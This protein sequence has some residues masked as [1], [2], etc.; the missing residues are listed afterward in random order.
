MD[1]IRILQISDIH[2]VTTPK[3]LDGYSKMREMF[4][5]DIGDYCNTFDRKFNHLLIC[6]DIAQSG[7]ESQYEKAK[8]YIQQIC[9]KI[10]C[11]ESEVYVVP[12]NHDKVR[13]NG[14]PAV[15]NL[16]QAGLS[17][18]LA[19]DGMFHRLMT[20]E[21][22]VFRSLFKPFEHYERFSCSFDNNEM[23]MH[24]C[25]KECDDVEF[26]IDPDN[27]EMYWHSLL[28]DDLGGYTVHLYGFNTSLNCDQNDWDEWNINGHKMYLSKFAY[29]SLLRKNGNDIYI[30]MMHHPMKYI[31]NG[32][33]IEKEI[34]NIFPL[35]FYGHVHLSEIL[36]PHPKGPVKVYSGAMQPP[37]VKDIEAK[38]KYIP[39]YN[40][41]E[42]F[43]NKGSD[44]KDYLHI[45][46]DVHRWNLESQAFEKFEEQSKEFAVELP[47]VRSRWTNPPRT[48]QLPPSITKR[49]IRCR[50]AER[51][52]TKRIIEKIY[53]D[54]YDEKETAYINSRLFLA[55]IQEDDR[56]I[57]L[58][59]EIK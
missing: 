52:D 57:D 7:E 21:V 36:Q 37:I 28:A 32:V 46:L 35:Q 23:M 13:E 42:L 30:S 43:I 17:N 18:E 26:S 6:G 1:K 11:K 22:S 55:K 25:I 27:D 59:D 9:S 24:K 29:N 31:A 20:E 53:K 2:R 15:R 45:K 41:V 33:E 54:L 50:F 49:D 44:N 4:L 48:S 40:I 5:N 56:W 38:K 10:D 51:R 16:I 12:G 19:N 3:A 58:W 8:E 34:D 14:N 47:Q 39:I